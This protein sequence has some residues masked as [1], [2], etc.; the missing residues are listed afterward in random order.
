MTMDLPVSESELWDLELELY[1]AS[2]TIAGRFFEAVQKL[3]WQQFDIE[4]WGMIF[5]GYILVT[6]QEL[7]EAG[8]LD[9]VTRALE[10][11]IEDP[12]SLRKLR[13]EGQLTA[14]A[15]F[16]EQLVNA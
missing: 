15:D 10:I 1:Y 11:L 3:N 7:W 12:A 16:Y 14:L 8:G 6:L 4:V 9:Y 13:S 5:K 2:E